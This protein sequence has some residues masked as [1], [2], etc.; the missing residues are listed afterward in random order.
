M[1]PLAIQTF[2]KPEEELD[3][4]DKKT[5]ECYKCSQIGYFTCSCKHPPKSGSS[6]A[7]KKPTRK[8]R[9]DRSTL[10]QLEVTGIESESQSQAEKDQTDSYYY[11][12]DYVDENHIADRIE[13]LNLIATYKL[14]MH[15]V[16]AVD[17]END[18]ECMLTGDLVASSALLRYHVDINRADAK[19]VIDSGATT[20]FINETTV[21]AIK[22]Q[23][24]VIQLYHIKVAG[25]E[26]VACRMVDRVA[27]L[28]VK[29]EDIPI[30]TIYAYVIALEDPKLILRCG[31]LGKHNS[32]ILYVSRE[33]VHVD[34]Q[35][36]R[37][38]LINCFLPARIMVIIELFI[39][40][41]P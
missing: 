7:E 18:I 13:Y 10:Y 29:H 25:K 23:I 22:V 30:E 3:V 35:L 4:I 15:I 14:D 41:H 34:H 36:R 16:L 32:I 28:N 17:S 39:L 31:W 11:D 9:F 19:L 33:E 21:H 38:S 26:Q 20:Y 40:T 8:T 24:I 37:P 27:I 6:M 5:V 1:I 12:G 2:E